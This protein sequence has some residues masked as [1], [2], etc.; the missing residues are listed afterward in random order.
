MHHI[1]IPDNRR[2]TGRVTEGTTADFLTSVLGRHTVG[3]ISRS[4]LT[5][6]TDVGSHNISGLTPAA[7]GAEPVPTASLLIQGTHQAYA[8]HLGLGLRPEVFWYAVVSE[9]CEHIRQSPDRY[10][11]L[12]GPDWLD[13]P[14]ILHTHLWDRANTYERFYVQLKEAI[15]RPLSELFVPKLSTVDTDERMALIGAFMDAAGSYHD[16]QLPAHCRIPHIQVEGRPEDWLL[17][18]QNTDQLME[19]FP[20]LRYY[21][22]AVN[23]LLHS[24][25]CDI[26]GLEINLGDFWENLYE[27]KDEPEGPFVRGW[28]TALF[29]HQR[30][31]TGDPVLRDNFMWWDGSWDGMRVGQFASH[32]TSVPIGKMGVSDSPQPLQ[33]LISGVLGIKL[34]NTKDLPVLTPRLGWGIVKSL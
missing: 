28:I 1:N 16:Y 9:I 31:P 14:R 2:G 10:R 7:F 33:H 15:G 5:R 6:I 21:L 23:H 18:R 22:Q 27:W 25:Y 11:E 32:V 26:A 29:A 8:A 3:Q 34:T 24:I 20:A 17:L 4:K 12:L 13:G 30:M 19:L